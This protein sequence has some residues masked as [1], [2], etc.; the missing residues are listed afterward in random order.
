MYNVLAPI[1]PQKTDAPIE[2]D[3]MVVPATDTP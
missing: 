3:L 1:D 2:C